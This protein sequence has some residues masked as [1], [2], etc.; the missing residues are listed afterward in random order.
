MNNDF[1][2]ISYETIT[3]HVNELFKLIKDGK[4]KKFIQ[5]LSALNVNE[6]NVNIKD[7]N[8]NY[9]IFFSVILNNIN[10][11]KKLIEYGAVINVL[12]A[13]GYSI[14][15]YPIKLNYPDIINILI[16]Y[17][18]QLTGITLFNFQDRKGNTPLHYA[19]FYKN[20]YALQ[21]MLMNGADI[22]YRNNVGY[23]PFHM[24]I[25]KK[26]I[27]IIQII[28]KYGKFKINSKTLDNDTPLHLACNYQV[29]ECVQI[30]LD[31]GANI[32][33]SNGIGFLPI[34][35]S[36]IQNDM[37]IIKLFPNI[38][39]YHQDDVNGN[40]VLYYAITYDHSEII[41]YIFSISHIIEKSD[42]NYTENTTSFD[43]KT[44]NEIDPNIVNIEGLTIL[45]MLLYKYKEEF[46]KYIELLLPH[47]NVNYQDNHG[48]TILHILVEKDLWKKFESILKKKKLNIYIKNNE[49]R[50]VFDMV[51]LLYRELF[52][53]MVT[54][55][56]AAYLIKY[57]GTLPEDWQKKCSKLDSLKDPKCVDNIH[58]EI[59]K[60]KNSIPYRTDKIMITI[61]L[62]TSVSISTF[63]GNHLD[64]LAG[65][66][67][68]T[69]KYPDSYSLYCAKSGKYDETHSKLREDPATHVF[70][71]E[72]RWIYQKIFF[73]SD[74]NGCF[75]EIVTMKKYRWIIIPIGIILS[76]GNHS[77]ILLYDIKNNVIERFEPHG[78]G[79]PYQF[80]YN[81]ELLDE[82][83]FRHISNI[84]YDIDSS[85]EVKY[86][87]PEQYLPKVGFQI[88]ENFESH[89]N[90]NIGDPNGFC[91]LWCIW[92]IDY[93]LK[94]LNCDPKKLVKKIITN[95]RLHNYS[96]RNIIRNYSKKITDLRDSFLAIIGMDI[97]DYLNGRISQDNLE[98]IRNYIL[99]L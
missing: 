27:N 37:D 90:T 71:L 89:F 69:M 63:T 47:T 85:I 22:E 92:Y 55:S 65:V 62:D 72:I 75:R 8:D 39:L 2:I 17:D 60:N 1:D 80:N 81:P 51:P 61:D 48:Y 26:D 12:D 83:I 52:L 41:D 11:T 19:V 87:N 46:D 40:T 36:I 91:F 58:H 56:Y 86:I 53:E 57:S 45:H 94:Y 97:N 79:Y 78:S 30:L 66:K 7:E 33:E 93:R 28:N 20:T 59:V 82:I 38:N 35:Y 70:N 24:A 77:N 68:L 73:P 18:K 74:F 42:E 99:N 32:N 14:L 21:K 96:F 9:L 67:Y 23:N 76:N 49:D 25:I 16:D 3:N 44:P 15:Y 29:K 98:K 6:V 64:I 43:F 10:V 31:K 84:I 54:V 4:T 88:F 95:I 50:S 34:F 5:Y 13:N